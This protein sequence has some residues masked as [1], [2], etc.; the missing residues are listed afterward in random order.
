M[1]KKLLYLCLISVFL[2]SA[3]ATGKK[4]NN[5]LP[6]KYKSRVL[7]ENKIEVAFVPNRVMDTMTA[8]NY[9]L[10][11]CANLTLENGY[12]YFLVSDRIA[13][14]TFF[15]SKVTTKLTILCFFDIPAET[16]EDVYDAQRV[17]DFVEQRYNLKKLNQ[18]NSTNKKN[19]SRHKRKKW[20]FWGK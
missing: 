10:L 5:I 14:K 1:P 3:C 18:S 7:G 20:W 4:Q 6:G 16:L 12:R 15:S 17:K 2:L 13:E 9:A 19:T 11:K 8:Q